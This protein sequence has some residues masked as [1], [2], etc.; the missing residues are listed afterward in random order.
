MQMMGGPTSEE[1]EFTFLLAVTLASL[2][3]WLAPYLP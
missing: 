1:I 2:A 3:V